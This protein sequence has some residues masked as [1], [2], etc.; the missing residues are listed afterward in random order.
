[1]FTRCPQL[2][3]VAMNRA[4]LKFSSKIEYSW[5]YLS[6]ENNLQQAAPLKEAEYYTAIFTLQFLAKMQWLS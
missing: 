2:M 6:L 5:T 3:C 4:R 1:M